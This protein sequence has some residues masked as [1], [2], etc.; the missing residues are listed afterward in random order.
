MQQLNTPILFIIFNRP[1]LTQ[2]VFDEIK[3]VQPKQLFVAS[4]G[5]RNETDRLKVEKTREIIKQVDWDC[6]V[7]TNFSEKNLGCKLGV[8][9]GINWF[10]KNVKQG[11][12][13]EDDCLPSQSFF[14][15]CEELL[16]KYKEDLRIGSISGS[17]PYDKK[18]I[19]EKDYFFSKYN[20]IWGWATWKN[21]WEYNDVN[22]NFWPKIKSKS[23]H[24]SFLNKDEI[25]L[26]EKN[27][28]K[29]YNK[30]INTWDYQWFLCRSLH[31]PYTI[32]S[33]KNQISNIGFGATATHTKKID[34]NR[35]DIARHEISFPLAHPD[36]VCSDYKNDLEAM[37][38]VNYGNKI[39][40]IYSMLK[41][42][43][44]GRSKK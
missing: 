43:K 34:S 17:N 39:N 33:T 44:H 9:S 16:E 42:I 22:I 40:K 7:K 12:I 38:S 37:V 13:L 24:Y 14:W 11:I 18:T 8:S 29:A 27:W 31:F 15:F 25:I 2:K 1:D 21:R 19:S 30:S 10:F 5:P 36:I 6:Q 4:D 41:K 3:K 32:I 23:L 20:R 28:D 35:A 26:W